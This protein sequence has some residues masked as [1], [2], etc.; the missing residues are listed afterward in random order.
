MAVESSQNLS[1]FVPSK[2]NTE[3]YRGKER[4]DGFDKFRPCW[5]LHTAKLPSGLLRMVPLNTVV[6][7][8]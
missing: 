5:R 6:R 7:H 1:C 8:T 2:R 4:F 3:F